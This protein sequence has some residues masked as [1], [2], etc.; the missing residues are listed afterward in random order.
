MVNQD[1]VI[2][3]LDS[4]DALSTP[5][6]APYL[7]S[8]GVPDI[9]GTDAESQWYSNPDLYPG[10]AS[11][12]QSEDG[13]LQY[14]ITQGKPKIGILYCVEFALICSTAA[15]QTTKDAPTMGGTVVYNQQISLASPDYTSECLGAKSAGVQQLQFYGDPASAIRLMSDCHNQG[16]SPL[17]TTVAIIFSPALLA[18][19]S[20]VAGLVGAT[21]WF[22][23]MVQSPATA[24]FDNAFQQY[25]GGPP[26]SEFDAFS[27]V[28]GLIMQAA[29]KNLPAANPTS[30]ELIAGLDTIQNDTFGGLATPV[31][32]QAGQPAV[33]STCSFFMTVQ[34]NGT[35]GAPNGLQ[36][37]CLPASFAQGTQ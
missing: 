16:Y 37:T 7:A 27:W 29:S 19:S 32:Y 11:I 20:T 8:V 4:T 17:F 34:G 23:F 21:P 15:A 10:S 3:F 9:A 2:A 30:A 26:N 24:Q 28:G 25:T 5:T 1:H 36:Q 35:Y 18:S 13:A 33:S 31:T 22:P 6:L 12:R 14:G